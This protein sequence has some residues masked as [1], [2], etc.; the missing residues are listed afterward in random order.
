MQT[1]T[2]THE[3]TSKV[4]SRQL[5]LDTRQTAISKAKAMARTKTKNRSLEL[6]RYKSHTLQTS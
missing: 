1:K 2:D 5:T 3:A 4:K 6:T